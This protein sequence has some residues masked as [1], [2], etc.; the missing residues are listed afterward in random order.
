MAR[1]PD[2][3]VSLGRVS[4]RK[5][6]PRSHCG[7]LNSA[8][9]PSEW[10]EMGRAGCDLKSGLP[11]RCFTLCLDPQAQGGV[12]RSATD[13]LGVLPVLESMCTY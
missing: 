6:Q 13:S 7:G 4:N 1:Q 5:S 10:P 9:A 2:G 8:L 12:L 11:R 3:V